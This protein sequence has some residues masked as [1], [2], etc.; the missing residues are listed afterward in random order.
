MCAPRSLSEMSTT[1]GAPVA[2]LPHGEDA[3]QQEPEWFFPIAQQGSRRQTARGASKYGPSPSKLKHQRSGGDFS[4]SDADGVLGGAWD[5]LG[6]SLSETG[7]AIFDGL[8]SLLRSPSGEPLPLSARGVGGHRGR[9]AALSP[10]SV[11]RERVNGRIAAAGSGGGVSTPSKR[12]RGGEDGTKRSPAAAASAA[13]AGPHGFGSTGGGGGKSV[14]SLLARPSPPTSA[15][16]SPSTPPVDEPWAATP[17]PARA[18]GGSSAGRHC[19]VSTD[20]SPAAH[21]ARS[22]LDGGAWK[23]KWNNSPE[24]S[25]ARAKAS[26]SR[27]LGGRRKGG[28][29]KLGRR[30][31]RVTSGATK[32]AGSTGAASIDSC[33]TRSDPTT[34]PVPSP[35]D[36]GPKCV[37]DVAAPPSASVLDPAIAVVS[38]SVARAAETVAQPVLTTPALHVQPLPAAAAASREPTTHQREETP[39]P[40]PQKP[41]TSH[42]A[43]SE[44][45]TYVRRNEAECHKH[46]QAPSSVAKCQPITVAPVANVGTTAGGADAGEGSQQPSPAQ[47]A[48]PGV[49]ET[50]AQPPAETA[51]AAAPAAEGQ[52]F[53]A[54]EPPRPMRRSG[55][56]PPPPPPPPPPS[57][58]PMATEVTVTVTAAQM[59][60]S[61]QRRVRSRMRQ[62]AAVGTAPPGPASAV[63]AKRAQWL[64]I[65]A[66]ARRMESPAA[67]AAMADEK[68][69]AVQP[70]LAAI[71]AFGTTAHATAAA[72]QQSNPACDDGHSGEEMARLVEACGELSQ[73]FCGGSRELRERFPAFVRDLSCRRPHP[74]PAG[75]H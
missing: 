11:L 62:R 10:R 22:A 68:V 12:K 14:H 49:S 52:A 30:L 15:V 70:L 56:P 65:Q 61:L 6:V 32:E 41:A 13:V 66:K 4:T 7:T 74:H 51:A 21:A 19:T 37:L 47:Q 72:Q 33:R 55:A 43:L 60:S 73:W 39:A 28:P 16:R 38:A 64:A 57:G 2:V 27:T 23:I 48:P 69:A 44:S 1:S 31:S 3:A 17:P 59:V 18:V 26:Y 25:K 53:K 67:F 75:R 24:Q 71:Q 35:Q 20:D 54:P 63:D 40:L 29:K 8:F 5:E 58:G 42:S 45:P 9:A 50:A 34:A 36:T 46:Q